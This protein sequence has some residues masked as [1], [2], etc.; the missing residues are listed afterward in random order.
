MGSRNWKFLGMIMYLI[1]DVYSNK[2]KLSHKTSGRIDLAKPRGDSQ[3]TRHA[4]KKSV[5]YN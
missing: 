1:L 3:I 5:S 4:N 2:Q